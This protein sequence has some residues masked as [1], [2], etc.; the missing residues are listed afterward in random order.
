M[1]GK[2][3]QVNRG[4]SSR[5][6]GQGRQSVELLP[7]GNRWSERERTTTDTRRNLER[8]PSF[9]R[10]HGA[11]VSPNAGKHNQLKWSLSS[12]AC[13]LTHSL[14]QVSA[15][16]EKNELP[17]CCLLCCS[18]STGLYGLIKMSVGILQF[19]QFVSLIDI[20]FVFDLIE[21]INWRTLKTP[22]TMDFPNASLY[23]KQTKSSLNSYY[24]VC[25]K[26][27]K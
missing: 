20:V 11:P 15:V 5:Q 12:A 2:G 21:L 17:G 6:C 14:P 22:K 3:R 1:I 25:G 10:R 19:F 13:S 24:I 18:L 26:K 23:R 27:T 8:Q 4:S 16:D 9:A 7:V